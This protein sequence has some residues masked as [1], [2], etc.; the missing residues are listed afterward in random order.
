MTF[1]VLPKQRGIYE[2][3]ISGRHL[4]LEDGDLFTALR[5]N[6]ED[7]RALFSGLGMD[8]VVDPRGFVFLN[9]TRT[10]AN[11]KDILYFMAV[12]FE[13]MDEQG[14]SLEEVI[15]GSDF[16]YKDLPHLKH[17]KYAEV[18]ERSSGAVTQE[19]LRGIVSSLV[20]YRFATTEADYFRFRTP[21]HRLFDLVR[22]AYNTQMRNEQL[23]ESLPDG[24]DL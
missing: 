18:M 8:L 9:G 14:Y 19:G 7:Y 6:E 20:R 13:H 23:A 16:Y 17:Q 1:P 11:M 4:C 22:D 15:L 24:G 2:A 10:P 5:D 21:A 3:L 12:L